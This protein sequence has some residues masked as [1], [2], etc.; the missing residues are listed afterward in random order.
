MR[1]KVNDFNFEI[2]KNL[3]YFYFLM[4]KIFVLYTKTTYHLTFLYYHYY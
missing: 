4:T 3:L 1:Y 2:K